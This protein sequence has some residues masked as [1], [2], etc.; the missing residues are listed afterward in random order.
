MPENLSL[1]SLLRLAPRRR[2][3]FGIAKAAYLRGRAAGEAEGYERGWRE[4]DALLTVVRQGVAPSREA[5]RT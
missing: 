3:A 5:A 1:L 4:R 2:D